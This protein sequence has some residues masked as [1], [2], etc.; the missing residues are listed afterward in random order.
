MTYARQSVA[1]K[2]KSRGLMVNCPLV[3]EPM[4]PKFGCGFATMG[5]QGE[6][7]R[8]SYQE[9]TTGT[10]YQDG[11]RTMGEPQRGFYVEHMS[12]IN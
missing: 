6:L 10:S 4:D 7:M 5:E 3:A 1:V 8:I 11:F 12:I 2:R 9:N